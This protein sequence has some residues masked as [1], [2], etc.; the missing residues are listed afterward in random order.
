M[1][2]GLKMVRAVPAATSATRCA[3][4][5][6]VPAFAGS[7]VGPQGF[8]DGADKEVGPQR[9]QD[10]HTEGPEDGPEN[11]FGQVGEEI[12]TTEED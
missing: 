11:R 8:L 1:V 3:G 6:P 4:T 5:V 12:V 7:S 9:E 10:D 2:E